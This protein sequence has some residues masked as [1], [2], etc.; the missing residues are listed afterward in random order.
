MISFGTTNRFS[1]KNFLWVWLII[2]PLKWD[3]NNSGL[4]IFK[5]L[6]NVQVPKGWIA[7]IFKKGIQYIEDDLYYFIRIKCLK[8]TETSR[9]D[10]NSNCITEMGTLKSHLNDFF[11]LRYY[12]ISLERNIIHVKIWL[13]NIIKMPSNIFL[14]KIDR[15]Y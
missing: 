12:S 7:V 13:N 8:C 2:S 11:L 4:S 10:K 9:Q 1:L 6:N 5:S 15:S 3:W 14:Y